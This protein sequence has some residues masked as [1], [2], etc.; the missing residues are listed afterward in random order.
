MSQTYIF[1]NFIY[2]GPLKEGMALIQPLIN[3]KPFDQNITMIPWKDIETSS[4][5][6]IDALAC[7]KGS[8]HSVWGLNLYQIDVPALIKAINFMDNVYKQN[9]GFRE[10]FLALDMYSSRVTESVPD[11]ATAYPYRNATARL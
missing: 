7:I 8:F 4:K 3:L 6:G 10:A 5:F 9:P 2:V 1:A 11:D